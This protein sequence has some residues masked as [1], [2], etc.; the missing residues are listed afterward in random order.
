MKSA[1]HN[2][3]LAGSQ[4]GNEPFGARL[5]QELQGN[6]LQDASLKMIVANPRALKQNVC[7]VEQ[8]MN[9]A[10]NSKLDT[11]EAKRAKTIGKLAKNYEYLI[12]VHT[13]TS[14]IPPTLIVADLSHTTLRIINT[15]PFEHVVYFDHFLTANSLIGEHRGS[16]TFEVPTSYA[17]EHFTA[18]KQIFQKS[19]DLLLNGEALPFKKRNLYFSSEQLVGSEDVPSEVE[20]FIPVPEKDFQTFLAQEEAYTGRYL[21]FKLTQPVVLNA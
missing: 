18:L 11:Y 10:Y 15:L 6:F 2:V 1:R 5:I 7:Y 12:D 3:L 19:C 4:H 20:N 17:E 9:Q 16:V 8:N 13:T 21:G 14:M